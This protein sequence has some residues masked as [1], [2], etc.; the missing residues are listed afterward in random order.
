VTRLYSISTR[1][2]SRCGRISI[3][4]FKAAEFLKYGTSEQQLVDRIVINF[5]PGVLAQA[6]FLDRP[7]SLKEMYNIVGLLE[8]KFSV[9]GER[10]RMEE[11]TLRSRRGGGVSRDA[12]SST[13]SRTGGWGA[14][15]LRL[16]PV[17]SLQ[18]RLSF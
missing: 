7:R 4:V 10:R 18:E 13:P 6:A 8:E 12:S 1:K 9:A 17:W 14:Q 16:W 15:M 5:H 11:E 3:R 2:A